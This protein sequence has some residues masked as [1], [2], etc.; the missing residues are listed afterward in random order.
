MN[1]K[2]LKQSKGTPFIFKFILFLKIHIR[3]LR[4]QLLPISDF[5]L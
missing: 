4:K 2:K 5:R 1:N 3:L